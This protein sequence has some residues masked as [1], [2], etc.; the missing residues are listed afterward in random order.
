VGPNARASHRVKMQVAA[1]SRDK[2][3]R[4]PSHALRHVTDVTPRL[5]EIKSSTATCERRA[6]KDACLY[7]ELRGASRLRLSLSYSGTPFIPRRRQVLAFIVLQDRVEPRPLAVVQVSSRLRSSRLHGHSTHSC[8]SR[9]Y[10][11]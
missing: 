10:V 3:Q 6:G 2:M 5:T 7:Q 1:D 8:Q 4:C 9:S 11:L